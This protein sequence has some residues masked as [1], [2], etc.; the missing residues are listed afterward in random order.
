MAR[1]TYVIALK[2]KM[3]FNMKVNSLETAFPDGTKE[4][5]PCLPTDT[6]PGM[7]MAIAVM[8]P[9]KLTQ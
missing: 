6:E 9:S 1:G 5:G 4:G 7:R 3:Q 2:P 8:A